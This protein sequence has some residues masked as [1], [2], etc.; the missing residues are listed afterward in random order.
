MSLF[1]N[2]LALALPV[3]ILQVYDRV[4]FYQGITTLYALIIGVG[5]AIGFDFILRQARARLLQR[6]AV[7]IDARLGEK[8]FDKLMSLPLAELES[9]PASYWQLLFR[10]VD[11]VRNIFCGSTAVLAAD[12]P[13][14]ALFV[15]LIFIIAAPIAWV[16]IVAIPF[17]LLLTWLSGRVTERFSN[18][19][20]KAANNRDALIAEIVAGRVTVK[21]LALGESYK[22]QWEDR[23]AD[24][25]ELSFKRGSKGDSYI[26]MGLITAALTTVAVTG[27]GALAIIDQRL[28]I[29]ALIATNMLGNRIISPFNQLIGIWRYYAQ[30][31]QSLSRL[32]EIFALPSERQ[33]SSIALDRPK[34]EIALETVRFAYSEGRPPVIDAVTLQIKPGG[35]V[36][37][38]GNNGS[39]KTTLLKLMQGLYLPNDGRVT[40]DGADI[41]QFTRRELAGWIGYVPQE[42]RLFSGSIRDNIAIAYPDAREE[43]IVT[44]ARLAG[45]HDG[46]LDLPDGYATDTGEAGALLSGGVR[47]RISI[48]RAMLGDPPVLLLDEVTSNIDNQAQNVLRET[49]LKLAPDHT[50]VLVSHSPMLLSACSH[51]VVLDRGKVT[52]AGPAQEILPILFGPT[53]VHE[54]S[55]A[56]A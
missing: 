45:A 49:L 51:I 30:Y 1:I 50:I 19:E 48:A 16:F 39:G 42:C 47:Q 5:I 21:A 38:V 28:T 9:Q 8:L 25:I 23:H 3:F 12:L 43:E 53:P 14:V 10:D 55:E 2:I 22:P 18:E 27:I 44:A 40:L 37:L 11:T 52:A 26:N 20:R 32:G 29:G 36:G 33:E 13:F 56:K 17:F 6:A 34:G 4:V 15:L 7:L 31:K 54:V 46:I 35:I 41:H 24:T